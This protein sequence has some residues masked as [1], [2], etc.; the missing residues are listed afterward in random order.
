MKLPIGT[1]PEAQL[2]NFGQYRLNWRESGQGEAVVLLHGISS[3]SASWIC[4]LT[5]LSLTSHHRL[6]AWDAP[7]YLASNDLM[8]TNPVAL[9]YADAL[10]AFLDGHGL[11]KVILVGHSLGAMMACAFASQHPQRVTGLFLA[12]PAQ[13]YARKSPAERQQVYQQRHDIVFNSGIARYAQER[14]AALLS[15]SASREKVAWVRTNMQK[16][17]PQGFLSAAWMLAHDDINHSLN[18]YQGPIEMLVGQ[19]D[20]ITPPEQVQQLAN[21]KQCP[22]TVIA[23]AGHAS[24]LDAPTEFNRALS[25]FLI[26]CNRNPSS[27]RAP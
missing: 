23:Q 20:T 13:G 27:R 9:D 17:N 24:Y 25:H 18:A 4:Q 2:A 26:R 8:T 1:L 10:E 7:G 22:L 6:L 5:D 12:N 21:N 14:A 19:E 11:Q 15:P 16:L 3:G